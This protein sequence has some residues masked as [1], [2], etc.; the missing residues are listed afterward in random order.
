MLFGSLLFRLFGKSVVDHIH[1]LLNEPKKLT[2]AYNSDWME[3]Y[4][5][6]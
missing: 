2:F 5:K 6:G 4:M 3:Y 1:Y